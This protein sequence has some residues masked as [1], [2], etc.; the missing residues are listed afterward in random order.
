MAPFKLHLFQ[1]FVLW[2]SYQIC[3]SNVVELTDKNFHKQTTIH[4]Y[5]LIMFYANWSE[6]YKRVE[7]EFNRAGEQIEAEK[8]KIALGKMDCGDT[9]KNICSKNKVDSFPTLKLYHNG[10]FLKDYRESRVAWSIVKFMRAQIYPASE[11]LTSIDAFKKFLSKQYDA[12]LVGFF[13]AESRLKRAFLRLAEEM[14]ETMVFAHSKCDNL[15]K[16]QGVFDG[17]VLFRPI[18]FHNFY[19]RERM[20][21]TGKPVVGEI[22]T[23]IINHYHGLVGHRTPFNLFDFT[24]PLVIT[25]YSVD[26]NNKLKE[27]N[28][29]RTRILKVAHKYRTRFNFVVCSKNDFEREMEDFGVDQRRGHGPI[30]VAKT[31]DAKK[32]VM[33]DDFSA[34]ALDE[35]VRNILERK[36]VPYVKSKPIPRNNDGAVTIAVAHNFDQVVVNNNMDTLIQFYAPWCGHSQKF[37]AVYKELGAKLRSEDVA[38]VKMDATENDVPPEFPVSA[39]PTVYWLPKDDKTHPILYI[40]RRDIDELIRFVAK[41]ASEELRGYDRKGNQKAAKKSAKTEL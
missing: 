37:S 12:V 19:E 6:Y 8:P 28:Y 25:Y 10:K 4:E 18:R 1:I 15:L 40:G 5:I 7:P 35:F 30:V 13:E 9:G 22:K 24:S 17:I 33:K 36:L 23:F 2:I 39:Y 31:L 41:E 26:Y 14:K 34:E 20:L 11:E 3:S 38:V 29:W 27:P 21:Y 32:Y 16:K